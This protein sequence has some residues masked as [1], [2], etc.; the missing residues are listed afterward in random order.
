MG[1]LPRKNRRNFLPTF[2]V[3]LLLWLAV[4]LIIFKTS[5]DQV[6]L[7]KLGP[8]SFSAKSNIL[9]FLTALTATLGLTLSLIIGNSRRGFFAS[10]YITGILALRLIKMASLLNLLLLLALFITAEV[11]F[12]TRKKTR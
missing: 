1:R 7:F 8:L 2:L 4:A 12:S 6:S 9:L 5:P 3:N 11:Y 10:L